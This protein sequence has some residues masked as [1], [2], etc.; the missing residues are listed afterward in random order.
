MPNYVY[1]KLSLMKFTTDAKVEEAFLDEIH[2]KI[3]SKNADGKYVIDFNKIIPMPESINN[4]TVSEYDIDKLRYYTL[5]HGISEVTFLKYVPVI[6]YSTPL[7]RGSG[8][9]KTKDGKLFSIK[10]YEEYF[11]KNPTSKEVTYN[12]YD[13]PV[14]NDIETKKKWIKDG[15]AIFFNLINY[16]CVDW[17]DW[18]NEHWGTK[19]NACDP[20]EF[21]KHTE[22]LIDRYECSFNTAWNPPYPIVKEISKILLDCEVNLTSTFEHDEH[23][24]VNA[25][26]TN[27]LTNYIN[28]KFF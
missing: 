28:H 12:K 17:Y 6:A 1:N 24:I 13:I 26:Y 27:G 14:T 7:W 2:N 25:R 16:R 10:D 4:Y 22:N 9:M 21:I 23:E 8:I 11:E 3:C 19:W 20:T 15:E 18:A 5:T